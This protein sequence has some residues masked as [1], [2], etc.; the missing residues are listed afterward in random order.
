MARKYNRTAARTKSGRISRSKSS[1][2]AERKA[3]WDRQERDTMGVVLQARQRLHGLSGP[4]ARDQLAGSFIGRLC[5]GNKEGTG[6]TR[7]QYEALSRWE[8]SFRAKGDSAQDPNRIAGRATG[9][10]EDRDARIM[11][12]HSK[13]RL[14]VQD[15][16]NQLGLRANLFAALYECV[17]RDHELY[18]MVGD[19]REAAN[20][21]ARHYGLEQ[22]VAA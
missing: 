16:Q 12:A 15:R 21:L 4:I 19:L 9:E 2:E 14:A 6:I 22:Q 3:A 11:A 20:A 1:K 8:E 7:I 10:D 17:Q 13:A 5:L 18:H